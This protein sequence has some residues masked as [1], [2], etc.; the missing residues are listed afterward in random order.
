MGTV[1]LGRHGRHVCPTSRETLSTHQHGSQGDQP[2]VVGDLIQCNEHLYGSL[3]RLVL[4]RVCSPLCRTTSSVRTTVPH[5]FTVLCGRSKKKP[6]QRKHG[7]RGP[8]LGVNTLCTGVITGTLFALIFHTQ[9][10]LKQFIQ[11]SVWPMHAR[12]VRARAGARIGVHSSTRVAD[13]RIQCSG[14][15]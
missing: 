2:H 9:A 13:A 11:T 7:K 4:E 5:H 14:Y 15:E 6:H 8:K 10:F 1:S 3:V 12:G